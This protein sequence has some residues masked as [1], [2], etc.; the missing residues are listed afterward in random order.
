MTGRGRIMSRRRHRRVLRYNI[1]GLTEA[2][3][4]RLANKAG[5]VRVSKDIYD[6]L[7][8][9]ASDYLYSLIDSA[10]TYMI[11]AKRVTVTEEDVKHSLELVGS[12]IYFASGDMKMCPVS[13]KKKLE[14]RIREYQEQ[15]DCLI[16][17][18]LPI[19]RLIREVAQDYKSDTRFSENAL[20]YTQVALEDVLLRTIVVALK[21]VLN[22]KQTTLDADS[23]KLAMD[24][25]ES[26]CQGQKYH[27]AF[28]HKR[29]TI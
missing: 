8:T 25:M 12:K 3:F 18:R 16:F 14:T 17:P 11:H 23:L 13:H 6:E 19:I 27:V 20:I 5:A 21:I 15:K 9:I 4:R 7:R 1:H 26:T 29:P 2:A 22:K 10:I 28:N 24:I